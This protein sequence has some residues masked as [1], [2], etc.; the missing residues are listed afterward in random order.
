MLL[1]IFNEK[2]RSFI[3]KNNNIN[4]NNNF[5]NKLLHLLK[6]EIEKNKHNFLDQKQ[7]I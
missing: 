5:Y 7:Y 3:N 1:V 6:N 4:S 2:Q